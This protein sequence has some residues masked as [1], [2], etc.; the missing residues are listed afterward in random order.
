M[1]DPIHWRQ[2]LLETVLGGVAHSLSNRI[3]ALGS[4]AEELRVAPEDAAELADLVGGE[5]ARCESLVRQLRALSGSHRERAEALLVEDLLADAR[6]IC[7]EGRYRIPGDWRLELAPGLPPVWACRTDLVQ[8][9]TAILVVALHQ[10]GPAPASASITARADERTVTLAVR[11]EGRPREEGARAV[12]VE[13]L[14]RDA[15][16][17]GTS[18][19]VD[20]AGPARTITLTLTLPTLKEIRRRERE[21]QA[22]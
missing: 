10:A 3:T 12:D 8:L 20:A 16:D 6:A 14:I 17:A 11:A 5:A 22:P 2:L 7:Q 15:A 1:K 4:V 21:A 9:L 13:G 18:L 19:R